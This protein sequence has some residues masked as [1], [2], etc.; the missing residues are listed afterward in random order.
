M[1]VEKVEKL[2]DEWNWSMKNTFFRHLMFSFK[3]KSRFRFR[4]QISISIS[5]S[6]TEKEKK[7]FLHFLKPISSPRFFISFFK[8]YSMGV[9]WPGSSIYV[10]FLVG[11][12][13]LEE[14][15]L[16]KNSNWRFFPFLNVNNEV[17]FLNFNRF[18]RMPN[19]PPTRSSNN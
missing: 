12:M 3:F 7:S 16:G 4:F 14:R 18:V 1:K 6:T 10:W 5:I 13:N 2:I 15:V 11:I 8:R 19:R 9:S 17:V